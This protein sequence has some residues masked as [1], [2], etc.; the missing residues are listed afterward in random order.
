MHGPLL[1]WW[2]YC[3]F[4]KPLF[5]DYY[6]PIIPQAFPRCV[7]VIS[8]ER[9]KREGERGLP[10]FELGKEKEAKKATL[11]QLLSWV[12]AWVPARTRGSLCCFS[13]FGWE[14]ERA[15]DWLWRGSRQE[16]EKEKQAER[17]KQGELAACR[18]TADK[19][20]KTTLTLT[21]ICQANRSYFY[22]RLFAYILTKNPGLDLISLKC[23]E[24]YHFSTPLPPFLHVFSRHSCAESCISKISWPLVG[25]KIVLFSAALPGC[26]LF[27]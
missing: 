17:V 12:G 9:Q 14:L 1:L 3:L 10:V 13:L 20:S 18:V 19:Q 11:A 15:G 26:S 4:F 2:V 21:G 8:S 7:S 23:N 25:F 16:K 5:P 24:K 27:L 6:V 22:R